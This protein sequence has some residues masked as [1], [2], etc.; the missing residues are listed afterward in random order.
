MVQKC[1]NITVNAL[2]PVIDLTSVTC[3]AECFVGETVT[4]TVVCTNTGGSPGTANL[5]F[6]VVG[7]GTPTPASKALDVPANGSASTTF[8]YVPTSPSTTQKGC[9]TL[10]P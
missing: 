3:P 8:T 2:P 5:V 7:T 6:T 4:V 1:A 10:S 9:A